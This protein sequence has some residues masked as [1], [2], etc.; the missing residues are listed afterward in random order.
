MAESAIDIGVETIFLHTLI[1]KYKEAVKNKFQAFLHK[2]TMEN[3]QYD[4]EIQGCRP[5][6]L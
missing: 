4:L 1:L 3:I 6:I 5:T 2:Y